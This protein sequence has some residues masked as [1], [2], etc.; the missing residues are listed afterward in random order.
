MAMKF[1]V[2]AVNTV[3]N[4]KSGKPSIIFSTLIFLNSI[5]KS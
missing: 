5:D 2:R 3:K 1:L 4:E